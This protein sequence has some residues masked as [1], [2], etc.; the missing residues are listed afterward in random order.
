MACDESERSADFGDS[1]PVGGDGGCGSRGGIWVGKN[2][3]GAGSVAGE[4]APS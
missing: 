2:D 3:G 4:C 1:F